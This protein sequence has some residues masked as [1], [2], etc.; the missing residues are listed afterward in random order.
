[1]PEPPTTPQVNVSHLGNFWCREDMRKIREGQSEKFSFFKKKVTFLGL[2]R[3]LVIACLFRKWGKTGVA[4]REKQ[5]EK[6]GLKTGAH[7]GRTR[8]KTGGQK[9]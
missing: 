7:T 4:P 9:G 3:F 8:V 6:Q 1:M 5:G 2:W